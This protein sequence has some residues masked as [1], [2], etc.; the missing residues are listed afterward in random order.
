MNSTNKLEAMPMPKLVANMSLPLMVS[1]LV[2]SLY[3]IVD[4]I[5]V[6]RLSESALT[7]TSLAFPAQMLMI[8][9]GVGT[10]VGV[11]AVLSKNL[12]AKNQEMV[13]GC[14]T[15]GLLLSLLSSLVFVLFG[16]FGTKAFVGM[17]TQDPTIAKYSAQYLSICL[18]FCTGSLMSTMFQRFLQAAG[19]AFYSMMSL[20]AGALTNLILDPIFIF[21]LFGCPALGVSGA[22]IATV[23]GQWVSAAVAIWLNATK[24]PAVSLQW[25]DYRMDLKVVA[26]IYKVGLPTIVTQ[27]IGSV[28]VAAINAI[29]MP[30]SSTAV[31]FFGVYYKLQNF[32]FMPMNGLGQAAIPIV[33]YAF[34]AKNKERIREAIRTV[35]PIA[36]VI[37][38]IA[39][40][41]FETFPT[42]LLGFF[43]PSAEMLSIGIPA[44]R[45]IAITFVFASVTV[46]LGYCMSGLGNGMVHMVGTALRQ[47]I[48]LVPLVYVFTAYFGVEK[49]WYA[50]WV[51]ELAAVIYAVF[52]AGNTLKK[53]G[54]IGEKGNE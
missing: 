53:R 1:L 15:T 13:A 31:A 28:M 52:A 14:A 44:L 47:L 2:Q 12:G 10:G 38:L 21:G 32:L 17:F 8:A 11:N 40:V 43:S 20:I 34:G 4:S 39:T 45:I 51:S 3:N 50:V 26:Q 23:I 7:A 6:A 37:A 33:G 35:V 42:V 46:V 9:V 54:I 24:N 19:D 30:F 36:I 49:A 41:L 27:S 48:V 16:L 5:F 29:L 22:A 18:I 25:K